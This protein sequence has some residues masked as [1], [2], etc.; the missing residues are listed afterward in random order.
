[1]A[2]SF[3]TKVEKKD[4]EKFMNPLGFLNESDKKDYDGI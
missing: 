2:E 1:M 4:L 3:G